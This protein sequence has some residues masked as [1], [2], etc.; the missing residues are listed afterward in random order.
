M[1]WTKLA[2]GT[3]LIAFYIIIII[4]VCKIVN[5]K[6]VVLFLSVLYLRKYIRWDFEHG[7][8]RLFVLL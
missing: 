7:F 1:F 6:I 8:L 2:L 4:M 5:L 3:K